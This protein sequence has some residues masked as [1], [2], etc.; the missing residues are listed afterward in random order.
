MVQRVYES[1]SVTV[2]ANSPQEAIKL[3]EKLADWSFLEMDDDYGR[4]T[5]VEDNDGKDVT[6]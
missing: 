6:P 2:S 4:D 5:T 1:A 3:A